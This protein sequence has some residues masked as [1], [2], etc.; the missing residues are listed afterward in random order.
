MPSF[1]RHLLSSVHRLFE[2][3]LGGS[4]QSSNRVQPKNNA[5]VSLLIFCILIGCSNDGFNDLQGLWRIDIEKT[6]SHL[7]ATSHMQPQTQAALLL[8]K[9][10]F[11][12][13]RF[14]FKEKTL[15]FGTKEINR[16]VLL[17]YKGT[18]NKKRLVYRAS[19]SPFLMRVTKTEPGL[20]L[21]FEGTTWYLRRDEN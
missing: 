13:H 14:T 6:Q 8:S 16:T 10:I 18:E 21:D 3:T 2:P 1:E 17:E 19:D 11:S 12:R 4:S 15:T 5:P 7:S 9:G 20:I